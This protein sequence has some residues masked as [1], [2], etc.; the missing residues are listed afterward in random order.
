MM[1]PKFTVGILKSLQN[2]I[3]RKAQGVHDFGLF[4][5]S[6]LIIVYNLGLIFFCLVYC[7]KMFF[8]SLLVIIIHGLI[9]YYRKE[10]E[11]LG[12]SSLFIFH[13]LGLVTFMWLNY[14]LVGLIDMS[15][16]GLPLYDNLMLEFDILLFQVP[17]A[18]YFED[19]VSG[20]G[21]FKQ[22][23]YDILMV[24]YMMYYIFPF[25]GILLLYKKGKE[26]NSS[27]LGQYISSIIILFIFT[28]TF[29]L[30]VPVTG[31]QYFLR[32]FFREPLPLSTFGQFLYDLIYSLHPTFIDCFPSGHTGIALLICYW[33]YKF[34]FSEKYLMTLFS[35]LI[36]IST[37]VLRFHY[38]LDLI[39]AIPLVL[40]SYLLSKIHFPLVKL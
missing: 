15:M 22:I 29:Y 4:R 8:Q 16:G 3:E 13:T 38:I 14:Q 35:I 5:S 17:F 39:F 1:K 37:V 7:R 9:I 21:M 36:I 31:P 30:I 2:W 12:R 28:F 11:N 10:I 23:L 26:K 27:H 18:T 6:I 24:S 25:Y 20:W 34:N 19:Q 32:N 40:A 33:F